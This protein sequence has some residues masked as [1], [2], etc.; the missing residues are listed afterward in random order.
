MRIALADGIR[1]ASLGGILSQAIL[2]VPSLTDPFQSK[3]H[4]N[5]CGYVFSGCCFQAASHGDASSLFGFGQRQTERPVAS[6]EREQGLSETQKHLP[7]EFEE[8]CIS[9]DA[10]SVSRCV[11]RTDHRVGESVCVFQGH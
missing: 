8:F 5:H 10:W 4:A 3:G 1:F 7:L 2:A 11:I 6:W 9:S